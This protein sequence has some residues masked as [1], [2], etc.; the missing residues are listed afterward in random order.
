MK[1]LYI[2][3]MFGAGRIRELLIQRG[4]E[5]TCVSEPGQ[6]RSAI[7]AGRFGAVLI[8]E[9]NEAFKASNFVFEVHRDQPEVLVFPLSVWSSDLEEMFEFIEAVEESGNAP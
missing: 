2:D 6:A 7:R 5:V 8:A 3:P 1:I 4:H 9:Q